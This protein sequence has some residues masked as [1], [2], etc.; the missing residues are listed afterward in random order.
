MPN[1][2]TVLIDKRPPEIGGGEGGVR[3]IVL[4]LSESENH[5]L[6]SRVTQYPVEDGSPMTDH[7]QNVPDMLVLQGFVTNSPVQELIESGP[8]NGQTAFEALEEIHQTR[9]PVRVFT[10]LKEYSSMALVSLNVPKSADTGDALRFSA[11]FRK[12]RIVSSE[13]VTVEDLRKD[14]NGT[15]DRGSDPKDK[16]NQNTTDPKKTKM[17]LLRRLAVGELATGEL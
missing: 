7:I 15:T 8:R 11:T 13:T 4:D 14:D 6:E 17:S 16:G 5:Q 3:A 1:G 10:T 2:A 12:I 9:E